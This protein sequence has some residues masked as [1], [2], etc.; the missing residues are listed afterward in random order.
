MKWDDEP[1]K[2]IY[3]VKYGLNY[4]TYIGGVYSNKKD[5]E[6]EAK[7]LKKLYSDTTF[8]GYEIL[9]RELE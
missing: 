7:G 3:I 1:S 6:I 4:E 9:E 8:N 5:A 2:I